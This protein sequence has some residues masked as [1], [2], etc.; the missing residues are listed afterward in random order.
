[1]K[2][3]LNRRDFISTASTATLGALAA[4]YPSTPANAKI[5]N[6]NLNSTADTVIVL[7]LA[8]LLLTSYLMKRVIHIGNMYYGTVYLDSLMNYWYPVFL[9]LLILI[10][11][12]LLSH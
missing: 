3:N 6:N 8:G 2:T 10:C 7:W 12:S 4:G 9:P 1:M 11:L 5:L